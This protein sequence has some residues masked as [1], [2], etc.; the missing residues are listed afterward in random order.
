MVCC[1]F[2]VEFFGFISISTPTL[3]F[4]LQSSL[5][6][7]FFFPAEFFGFIS[8]NTPTFIEENF[9]HR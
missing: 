8:I 5:F 7:V 3:D 9:T 1:F 2:P 6:V 4:S